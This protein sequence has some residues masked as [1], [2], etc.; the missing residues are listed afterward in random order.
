[1]A[2]SE[3]DLVESYNPATNA[4]KTMQRMPTMRQSI[5]AA[6]VAGIMY[7]IGGACYDDTF[8][9]VQAYIPP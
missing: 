1:M 2:Y 4:W 9:V 8:K 7:V 5:G 6:V 3:T